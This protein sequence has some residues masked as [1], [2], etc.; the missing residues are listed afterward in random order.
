MADDD[1]NLKYEEEYVTNSRGMKLFTCNWIPNHHQQ[2]KALIFF[3]HGYAMECSVSMK[4]TG[5]RLAAAGYTVHGID[6]EGHGKSEGLLGFVNDIDC[7][8]DDCTDHF[9]N[10]SQKQ[11]NKKKMRFLL[12]ESM[13]GAVALLIHQ[14]TPLLWDGAVLVAPMCKIADELKPPPM[15]AKALL[16]IAKLIPTWRVVPMAQ[17][18]VDAAFRLP[19]TRKEIREN[20][21]CYKGRPRLKTAYELMRVSQELEKNLEQINLAFI[22]VHGGADTVTDP[23]VSQLLYEKAASTDK[24]F[25]LYPGM[26]H[27]LLYGETPE[28]VDTVF[29]DIIAWLDEKAACS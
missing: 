27:S 5:I 6:Y 14:K 10:I 26:W 24:T 25:K 7:I 13:G 9:T 1:S 8:V 16:H 19:E 18:V 4:D 17:D 15:V 29:T 20:P 22:V 2:S 12:G 21:Y 3:C 11:E 28:N 23:S